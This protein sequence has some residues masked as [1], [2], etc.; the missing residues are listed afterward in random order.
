MVT[1][2]NCIMPPD[3]VLWRNIDDPEASETNSDCD[4]EQP[5]TDNSSGDVD[6][7]AW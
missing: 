7:Y 6:E 5:V 1:P 2:K 4:N 3:V